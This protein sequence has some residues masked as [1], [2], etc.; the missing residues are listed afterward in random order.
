MSK[1][2]T[3]AR[4]R[5]Q[6]IM[7]RASRVMAFTVDAQRNASG[8][9]ISD[10]GEMSVNIGAAAGR[11]PMFEGVNPEFCRIVGTA[12]ASSMIEYKERHGHY[13]PADQL[14]NA[15]RALENLMIESALENMKATARRCLNL[16]QLTC[17]PLMA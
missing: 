15:S 12:W 16:S 14:A 11:D 1:D 5:E 10:R 9:M 2:I 13:P 17:A 7:T 4:M 8:A 6:D 3:P